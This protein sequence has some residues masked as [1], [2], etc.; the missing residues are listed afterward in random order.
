MIENNFYGQHIVNVYNHL[1]HKSLLKARKK[2]IQQKGIALHKRCPN[3]EN[4]TIVVINSS[5]Y[6]NKDH[7][8]DFKRS[9]IKSYMYGAVIL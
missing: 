3:S 6:F 2:M 9:L 8:S 7:I 4:K 1:Y 5:F